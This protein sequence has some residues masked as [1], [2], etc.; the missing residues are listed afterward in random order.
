MWA[1]QSGVAE[2]FNLLGALVSKLFHMAL[3]ICHLN[4]ILKHSPKKG[5]MSQIISHWTP[6]F[7][8]GAPPLILENHV[9]VKELRDRGTTLF[10]EL[11]IFAFCCVT[12]HKIQMKA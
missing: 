9:I 12:I 8:L 11:N 3:L 4:I 7:R 5:Q 6:N 2:V 1:K 10:I